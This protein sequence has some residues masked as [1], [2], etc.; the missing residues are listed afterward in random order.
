MPYL[1]RGSNIRAAGPGHG[2][3]GFRVRLSVGLRVTSSTGGS[4]AVGFG[5]PCAAHPSPAVEGSEK[6]SFWIFSLMGRSKSET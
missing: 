3:F 6:K 1:C 2:P 4:S 5:N